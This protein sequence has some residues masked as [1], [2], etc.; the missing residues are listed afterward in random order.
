[1]VP[2]HRLAIAALSLSFINSC[3]QQDPKCETRDHCIVVAGESQCEAGYRW[4]D[5]LDPEH[6]RCIADESVDPGDIGDGCSGLPTCSGAGAA[7]CNGSRVQ[8][9][10][11]VGSCL[12]WADERTCETPDTCSTGACQPPDACTGGDC[13]QPPQAVLSCP[14]SGTELGHAVSLDASGSFDTDG[15]I[16]EYVFHF[17]DDTNTTGTDAVVEHTYTSVGSYLARAVVVDDQGDV[18][19]AS[20]NIIIVTEAVD[21]CAGVRCSLIPAS[22]CADTTTRRLFTSAGTCSAGVC[23]FPHVDETCAGGCV[24]GTCIDASCGGSTCVSSQSPECVNA[25]F[26][27][28]YPPVGTCNLGA[29]DYAGY[30]SYCSDGCAG[31]ACAPGSLLHTT[32]GGSSDTASPV[33]VLDAQGA[34]HIAYIDDSDIMV[35]SLLPTGWHIE[36]VDTQVSDHWSL[37][38]HMSIDAADNLHLAYTERSNANVRYAVGPG[39]GP[40]AVEFVETAASVK[41]LA[42][43]VDPEGTPLILLYDRTNEA[44]KLVRRDAPSSWMATHTLAVVAQKMSAALQ[45]DN[46]LQPVI[47]YSAYTCCPNSVVDTRVGTPTT[48]TWT[49]QTIPGGFV[50]NLQYH[51]ASGTVYVL[52]S[53]NGSMRVSFGVPPAVFVAEGVGLGGFG[54]PSGALVLDGSDTLHVVYRRFDY[55]NIYTRTAW[56]HIDDDVWTYDDP[57]GGASDPLMSAVVDASGRLH[58]GVTRDSVRHIRPAD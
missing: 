22:I 1:M 33:L 53:R 47:A 5:S 11:S 15:S 25:D 27:R 36:A 31:S 23:I 52:T 42:I 37:R 51:M 8:I 2:I 46:A 20:C 13:N 56:R 6:L 40:F 26:L 29:C 10:R 19:Q 44:I 3:S 41:A 21:P 28:T 17:G 24:G 18:A 7:R 57:L 4:A 55:P 30:D 50:T 43:V 38:V 58:L 54:G 9:C 39:G 48:G 49:T 34:P 32:V 16:V 45:L 14:A 35:A 12:V